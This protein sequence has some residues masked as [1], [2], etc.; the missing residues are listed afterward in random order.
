MTTTAST[1]NLLI[2]RTSPEVLVARMSGNWQRRATLPGVDL[3]REALSKD[4]PAKF[5]EFDTAG[6]TG[7][8]S[9]FVAFISQCAAMVRDR[10]IEL[11]FDG[12]P[13]GA[14]RFLRLAQAVARKADAQ[15]TIAKATFFRSVGERT[16]QGWEGI[17]GLFSFLGQNLIALAKLLRGRAQFRW[18]DVLQ[19]MEQTGPQALAIVAMINFLEGLILAFVG[20]V[21]LERFGASIYVADL[22]GIAT[23]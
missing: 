9:R 2:E 11:Q 4:P 17:R 10:H 18:A 6:L 7:W 15:R 21:E 8:D 14:R 5:L 12:L 22:V 19:V 13:E 23:V 20:A 3:V 16:I 1:P